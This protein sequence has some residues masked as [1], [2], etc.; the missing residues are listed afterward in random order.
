[1]LGIGHRALALAPLSVPVRESICVAQTKCWETLHLRKNKNV[2]RHKV[3]SKTGVFK[4]KR[5][6]THENTSS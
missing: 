6:R 2:N 4:L 3:S 1:M 5:E